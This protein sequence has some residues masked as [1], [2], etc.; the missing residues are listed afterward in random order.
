M[1]DEITGEPWEVIPFGDL[2]QT[3]RVPTDD[4]HVVH[5]SQSRTLR[6]AGRNH[7]GVSREL[8]DSHHL[9][10]QTIDPGARDLTNLW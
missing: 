9:H 8:H 4:H 1:A 7:H 5:R 3:G 6:N 2:D 10:G